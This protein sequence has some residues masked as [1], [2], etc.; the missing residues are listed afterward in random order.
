MIVT[1]PNKK[2]SVHPEKTAEGPR[3]EAIQ[4]S[5][6]Q[7]TLVGQVRE[8]SE[9]LQH[10]VDSFEAGN[11]KNFLPKCKEIITDKNI[12]DT[13]HDGLKISFKDI[14]GPA[15]L[16]QHPFSFMKRK[17]LTQKLY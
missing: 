14:P 5:S 7:A 13:V 11:I 4:G 12:L 10:F 9:S 15:D 6:K 1:S 3:E 16:S 17:L 8:I 2:P